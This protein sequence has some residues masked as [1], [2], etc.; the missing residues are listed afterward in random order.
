MRDEEKAA[1]DPQTHQ[2][3]G[4]ME[5]GHGNSVSWRWACTH[6]PMRD[7]AL[8]NMIQIPVNLPNNLALDVV[9]RSH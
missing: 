4:Q 3:R 5:T 2:R 7:Q 6:W 8:S 9:F 1:D